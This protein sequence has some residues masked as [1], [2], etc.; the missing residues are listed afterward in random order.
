[1]FASAVTALS[2]AF[3]G[4]PNTPTPG[5]PPVAMAPQR[6]WH[7]ASTSANNKKTGSDDE[8]LSTIDTFDSGPT[9]RLKKKKQEEK[10]QQRKMNKY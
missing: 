4:N 3:G 1:M 2:A 10:K 5:V 9:K 8:S 7:R 6:S